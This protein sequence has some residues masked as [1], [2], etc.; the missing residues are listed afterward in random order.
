MDGL[1]Q[2]EAPARVEALIYYFAAESIKSILHLSQAVE[3]I[4]KFQDSYQG[5]EMSAIFYDGPSVSFDKKTDKAIEELTTSFFIEYISEDLAKTAA[6]SA[7]KEPSKW[8]T[9][10]Q[11]LLDDGDEA[12]GVGRIYEALQTCMWSNMQKVN[13]GPSITPKI[14]PGVPAGKPDQN[15]IKEILTTNQIKES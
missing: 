9:T 7:G 10:G 2:G 8:S 3:F 5:A 6:D 13:V 4:S 15:V 14:S 1:N 11:G 12:R